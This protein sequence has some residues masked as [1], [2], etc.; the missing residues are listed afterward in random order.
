MKILFLYF[1]ILKKFTHEK[2][3]FYRKVDASLIGQRIEKGMLPEK[4]EKAFLGNR[5]TKDIISRL[6]KLESINLAFV[7]M[8]CLI[9]YLQ[10]M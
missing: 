2:G 1:I 7:K 10:K 5:V 9:V 8:H 6:A 4:E 3:E